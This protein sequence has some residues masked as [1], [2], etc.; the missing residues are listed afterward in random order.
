LILLTLQVDARQ[1]DC[2]GH[3]A[4]LQ[5]GGTRERTLGAVG[6][7]TIEEPESETAMRGA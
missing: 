6:V 1:A 2:C 3:L 7:V 4:G 5:V